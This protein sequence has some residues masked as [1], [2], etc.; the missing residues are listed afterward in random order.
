MLSYINTETL[1]MLSQEVFPPGL[2]DL[3][4]KCLIKDPSLRPNLKDLLVHPYNR[5]CAVAKVNIEQWASS[6]ELPDF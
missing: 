1:P 6:I 3:V 5:E 4:A 2:C